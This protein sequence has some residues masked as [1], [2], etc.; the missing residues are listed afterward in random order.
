MRDNAYHR[1]IE[2]VEAILEELREG[3][4]ST[5]RGEQLKQD[6]LHLVDEAEELLDVGQGKVVRVEERDGE[7]VE[8]TVDISNRE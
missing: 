8:E 7:I 2:Q 4:I 5:E 6:A 1:K 3:D